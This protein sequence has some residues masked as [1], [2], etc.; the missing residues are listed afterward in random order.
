[1]ARK[2]KYEEQAVGSPGVNIYEITKEDITVVIPVLNEEEAIE[3]VLE[4]L[5]EEGYDR[6]LVVD[7]FSVDNTL[8]LARKWGVR[9][10]TQHGLGKAGALITAIHH[11]DTPYIL[12]MDGDYTYPASEIGKFLHNARRFTQIL[13]V[14]KA[15]R[16]NIPLVN[17]LGNWLINKTVNLVYGSNLTDICTGMY[18][19]DTSYARDLDIN[20]KSFDVE[21]EI[22][23]QS[24]L[25][26]N[27]TEVPIMYRERK[28]V[29]KLS[30]WRDGV[31]IVKTI[32]AMS[33]CYNPTFF[34][35]M[36]ASFCLVPGV[37]F[38]VYQLH[39]RYLYGEPYWSFGYY[40]LGL[41]LLIIGVNAF[42]LAVSSL[43]LRRLEN[44]IIK[45]IRSMR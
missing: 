45:S 34:L 12:L 19:L 21:V 13:G 6:I 9:F 35:S 26:G 31:N 36:M 27:I 38:V 41:V 42:M 5:L 25:K 43:V 24:I 14:R 17:R 7:G 33:M 18:L 30:G 8:E 11:V 3:H 23:I 29:T 39:V 28:G 32:M 44:R 16:E 20:S 10:V 1:M 15:G 22:A 40:S 2:I 37:Y 4:E